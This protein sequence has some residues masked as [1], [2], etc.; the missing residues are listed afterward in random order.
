[1][2]AS[3]DATTVTIGAAPPGAPR[4]GTLWLVMYDRK[5]NVPIDRG[6]NAGKTVTYNN[7]VR[8]LRP[9]AMWKG[10][11]MTVD[12]PKSEMSDANIERCAVILQTE[13]RKKGQLGPIIG[14]ASI[15]YEE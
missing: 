6:E 3:A 8:K 12:L 15:Y 11:P 14:A 2:T 4:K 7:V 9:I 1:M 13:A 5:V 10:D